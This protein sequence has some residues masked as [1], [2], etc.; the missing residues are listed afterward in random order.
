MIYFSLILTWDDI[1]F[2]ENAL[3]VEEEIKRK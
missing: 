2:Q 3:E 1:F